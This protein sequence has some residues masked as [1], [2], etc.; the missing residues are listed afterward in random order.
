MYSPTLDMMMMIGQ[1]YTTSWLLFLYIQMNYLY[2]QSR[3]Q[4]IINAI[5]LANGAKEKNTTIEV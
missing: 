3:E 1:E 4:D 2:L 5:S